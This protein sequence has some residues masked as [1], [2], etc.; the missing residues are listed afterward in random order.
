MKK[1]ELLLED[2]TTALQKCAHCHKLFTRSQR[3]WQKCSKVKVVQI[4]A[5]GQTHQKHT[6]D[7]S[8]DTNKFV[9]FMRSTKKL[10]WPMIFWKMY[11]SI[12]DFECVGCDERFE[13]TTLN[14]CSYHPVKSFF[15][16]N[17]NMGF[18]SCCYAES[19]RFK[20]RDQRG[21]CK[22]RPHI[23]EGDLESNFDYWTI[24]KQRTDCCEPYIFEKSHYGTG[25]A[26]EV[27]NNPC[28]VDIKNCLS[29]LM[30]DFR[31]E[32]FGDD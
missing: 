26:S 14:M 17:Q 9:Q 4:D 28:G 25:T 8:W 22:T 24:Y 18:Y 10:E 32:V 12:V 6:V 27:C 7:K 11:A 21:G 5:I 1:L 29:S 16:Y 31:Q 23:V 13:G 20:V 3:E 19:Q 15:G 30:K 2:T